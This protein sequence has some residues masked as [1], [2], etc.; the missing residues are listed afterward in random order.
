MSKLLCTAL[1]VGLTVA[2]ALPARAA[3][4]AL[5]PQKEKDI[6]VL[7]ELSGAAK[8]SQQMFD[9]VVG[10]LQKLHPEIPQEF[11]AGIA[12]EAD[13]EGFITQI[14]PIYANH[15]SNDEIKE[16]IK[17]YESPVGRKLVH[18]FPAVIQESA[19]VDQKWAY[20]LNAKV[21]R[22]MTEKGYLKS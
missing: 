11:W 21:A 8:R 3:D 6:R 5:D 15:F 12:K 16:L 1:F 10:Q 13:F 2:L 19:Q 18:E 22:R 20:D 4:Q 17:F 14:V 9:A 7:I